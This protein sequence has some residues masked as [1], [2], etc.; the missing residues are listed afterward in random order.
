MTG[1][2]PDDGDFVG[3]A[4]STHSLIACLL[5]VRMLETWVLVAG[6]TRR[7]FQIGFKRSILARHSQR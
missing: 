5:I 3:I 7:G 1:T 4:D 6:V 2:R